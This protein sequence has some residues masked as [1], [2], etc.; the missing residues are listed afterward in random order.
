MSLETRVLFVLL[1][2]MPRVE[3]HARVFVGRLPLDVGKNA[4]GV[5]FRKGC[6]IER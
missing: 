4:R 5:V 2:P 6:C 1:V 3:A